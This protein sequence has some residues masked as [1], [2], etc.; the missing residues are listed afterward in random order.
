MALEQLSSLQH[1]DREQ[2]TKVLVS[3]VRD[4]VATN[5]I[6]TAMTAAA[7]ATTKC[8]S[9]GPHVR[10]FM[11]LRN[12]GCASAIAHSHIHT[13]PHTQPHTHTQYDARTANHVSWSD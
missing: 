7:I 12:T 1:C 8:T 5:S 9:H 13:Q 4:V 2:S 11:M 3:Q 10:P 6:A